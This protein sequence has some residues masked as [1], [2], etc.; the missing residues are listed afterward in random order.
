MSAALPALTTLRLTALR[1][2]SC[3]V[4]LNISGNKTS[5]ITALAAV[6]PS[7][8][9]PTRI[10]SIDMGIRNLAYCVLDLCSSPLPALTT[11]TRVTLPL[12][13]ETLGASISLPAFAAATHTLAAGLLRDHEPSHI[14]IERQRWRSCGGSKVQEW[15]IRVN[16]VEAMLHA[17]LLG[18]RLAGNW[19]GHV[20]SVDPGKVARLWVPRKEGR[21]NAAAVKS[22]KKGVVKE[23]L[24]TGAAVKVEE[25]GPEMTA[26][27]L[28]LAGTR[29]AVKISGEPVT[30]DEKK[31][32][33]LAD[34]V[35]QAVAWLRWQEGRRRLQEGRMPMEPDEV[36]PTP[37]A[38]P[39]ELELNHT[40]DTLLAAGA[41]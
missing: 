29:R 6:R 15:T 28:L 41:P 25:G 21:T 31:V 2:V 23:W 13:V 1:H 12:S 9:P 30:A 8:T 32:D 24:R 33:D 34:C 36:L 5:L 3:L 10:L 20:E 14:L 18:Q 39:L 4:G 40:M 17:T 35:L 37:P 19:D 7:P 27:L 11:W 16:I 22:L 38:T 26:E